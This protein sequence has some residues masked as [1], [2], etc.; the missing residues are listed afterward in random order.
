MKKIFLA[1]GAIAITGGLVTAVLTGSCDT[2]CTDEVLPSVVVHLVASDGSPL[3][4]DNVTYSVED[5]TAFLP[6]TCVNAECSEWNVG[7][8]EI[9]DF[10]I[11]VDICGGHVTST[12]TVDMTADGCH[13]DTKHIYVQPDMAT[14]AVPP[15][16]PR[17]EPTVEPNQLPWRAPLPKKEC[18]GPLLPSV[19]LEIVDGPSETAGPVGAEVVWYDLD[20]VQ[21]PTEALCVPHF[22]DPITHMPPE[23][24]SKWLI[25]LEQAGKFDV[26]A[27][28]CNRRYHEVVE[29]THQEDGCHVIP[30]RVKIVADITDCPK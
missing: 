26:Y 28:V 20:E 14:C 24:C 29:V 25:G 5:A 11:D 22:E 4:A 12:V 17:Q 8:E 30:E 7:E 9:G 21:A 16:P 2:V 15:P 6:G 10:T 1:T 27:T 19:I 3:T 23:V 18:E 13:V